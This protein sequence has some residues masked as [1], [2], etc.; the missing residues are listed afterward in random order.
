MIV[1]MM[2]FTKL[3]NLFCALIIEFLVRLI[4]G[5]YFVVVKSTKDN[6]ICKRHSVKNINQTLIN[7][8]RCGIRFYADPC[9]TP[10]F[11]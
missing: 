4:F 5:N 8:I 2:L 7:N 9:F 6:P 1:D 10:M 3:N 11:V